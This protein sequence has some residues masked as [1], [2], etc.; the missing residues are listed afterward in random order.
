[1][2]TEYGQPAL[3]MFPQQE[4]RDLMNIHQASMWA[5]EYLHKQV[6]ASNISYLIQ[7]G[8]INK[9]VHGGKVVVS[10]SDLIDYYNNDR[11]IR[12]STWKNKFGDDLNWR[13]SFDSV[14]EKDTTKHVH[15]LHPYK[16]K[17][18]PQLVEYF[19]DGHTDE[20]KKEVLSFSPAILF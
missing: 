15:R 13:L 20:F 2:N 8:K 11:N 7:Y 5:S 6:T 17:F 19:L 3:C 16:G 14:K 10:K 12:A 18:I 4:E 1:M 9:R